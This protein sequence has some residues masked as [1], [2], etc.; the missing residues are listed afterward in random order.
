M[1][2]FPPLPETPACAARIRRA[3]EALSEQ[4]ENP[5]R[6]VEAALAREELWRYEEAIALYRRGRTVAP[7]DYRMYL[8]AA[9]RLIRLRR[10]EEALADLNRSFELDPQGF[11]TGYLR[12]LTW[13]LRGDFE[14]SAAEYARLMALASDENARAEGAT[15]KDRGDPRTAMAIASDLP[16]RI[17]VTSWRYRALRRAGRHDEAA[18]LL[19]TVEDGLVLSPP[20]DDVYPGTII[21]PDSNEPYYRLLLF[22]RGFREE[23]EVLDRGKLG[24][25]WTTVAYGV[26]VFHLVEGRA[27]R[28]LALLDE[29]AAEP[30]WARLGHVAAEVDRERHRK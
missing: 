21:R 14:S 24:G 6:I 25:Q 13:Y 28:A 5:D 8:G 30:H 2:R 12:A 18:R 16:T 10:F 4:P 17:A 26:A 9:H 3:D 22:Y 23:D 27:F 15:G 11:N 7:D 29:I 20:A 1:E 19:E